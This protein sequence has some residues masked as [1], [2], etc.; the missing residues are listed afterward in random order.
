MRP[1]NETLAGGNFVNAGNQRARTL[2]HYAD[3]LARFDKAV[4]G[5]RT[6]PRIS[7]AHFFDI[8][9]AQLHVNPVELG[10]L[11]FSTCRWTHI[12]GELHNL[13]VIK[14]ATCYG[15][16]RRRL[17]RLFLNL[18][19]TAIG[20]ELKNTISG[21]IA[22]LIANHSRALCPG[23]CLYEQRAKFCAKQDVS[24]KTKAAGWSDDEM[25]RMSR[26][27]ACISM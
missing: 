15:H 1:V 20:V 17:F 16:A 24:P 9:F 21:G 23:A 6:E 4:I 18:Q 27:P 22:D 25:I 19:C 2:L 5:F 7:S 8:E 3:K 11:K 12:F 14:I 26:L 13:V 10:Y